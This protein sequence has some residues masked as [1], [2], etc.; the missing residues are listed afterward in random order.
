MEF[1]EKDAEDFEPREQI[2]ASFLDALERDPIAML[3][4][5]VRQVRFFSF[6]V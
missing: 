5:I 6:K 1:A 3:R 4:T 2:G